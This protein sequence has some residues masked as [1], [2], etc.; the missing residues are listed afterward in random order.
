MG[1]VGDSIGEEVPARGFAFLV[2]QVFSK[3]VVVAA[4]GEPHR[5]FE[6]RRE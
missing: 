6:Q 3:L 4:G 1:D 2:S 5:G